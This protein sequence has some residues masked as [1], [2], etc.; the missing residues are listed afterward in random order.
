M[1]FIFALGL[2]VASIIAIIFGIQ[3]D[4]KQSKKEREY[5]DMPVGKILKISGAVVLVGSLIGIFFSFVRIVP[6]GEVGV[7]DTFGV[8][9]SVARKSGINL[10][11]PFSSMPLMSVQTHEVKEQMDVP[12]KEGLSITLDVSILY[13]LNPEKAPDVYRTVG[14]S[15][16][17]VVILPQFRSACRSAIVNYEAKALYN[18]GRDEIG[19]K[20]YTDLENMCEGRGVIIEKVLL[21]DIDFP[22]AVKDSIEQ[23]LQAEQQAEQM[24]FTID[25]E[26]QEAQ[27]KVIEAE[28]IAKA[29]EIINK[30]LTNQYL[31]HEAIK[32]QTLMAASPNHTTVY[33]PS[34]DNGIP[35][36]RVANDK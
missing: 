12:S 21:R 35:L 18:S 33:I 16:P 26:K 31:Q 10:I 15:Y 1:G 4:A 6:A 28:G 11:N 23:K 22:K 17:N 14:L 34:G 8:V 25:K 32:A 27:R 2:V 29:Q 5:S 19:N 7:V 3:Y 30:T 20:I 9:D 13:R 24:K 36:V